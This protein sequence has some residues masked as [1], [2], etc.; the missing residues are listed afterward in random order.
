MARRMTATSSS[1]RLI[2]ARPLPAVAEAGAEAEPEQ[3][4]S[5]ARMP[6][7]A[8]PGPP[9]TMPRPDRHDPDATL[10]RRRGACFPGAAEVGEDAAP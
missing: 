3:G 1:T 9:R 2:Q 5:A 4:S 6:P 10:G 7:S 8:P